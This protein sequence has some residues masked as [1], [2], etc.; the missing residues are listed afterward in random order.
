M[1]KENN[2]PD[3]D[4]ETEATQSNVLIKESNWIITNKTSK[5]IYEISSYEAK[6]NGFED[7]F[8]IKDPFFKTT[9]NNIKRNEGTSKEAI[10]ETSQKKLTMK[11]NVHLKL[12]KD[13][14]V[15]ELYTE[16]INFDLKNNFATSKSTVELKSDFFFLRGKEFELIEGKKGEFSLSFIKASASFITNRVELIFCIPLARDGY[17]DRVL[18]EAFV[19]ESSI[20]FCALEPIPT[21]AITDAVPIII[22]IV[23]KKDLRKFK[24]FIKTGT[25]RK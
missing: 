25:R 8:F 23:V 7:V 21:I 14:E 16:S 13:K 9:S 5:N 17:T 2:L 18:A 20:A 19:I 12:L 22:A 3:L 6:Q 15:L 1:V 24:E 11:S 4:P 10:L